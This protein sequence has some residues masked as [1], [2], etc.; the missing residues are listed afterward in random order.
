MASTKTVANAV[1]RAQN[2]LKGITLSDTDALDFANEI[3]QIVGTATFFDWRQATGTTFGTT[4]DTQDY[5]NVPSDFAA[6]KPDRVYIQDDAVST[7][8]LIPLTVFESLP[9][10]T[11][12]RSRPQWISVE[13]G[14]FRLLP[15]PNITRSVSGQWAVKFEYWKR[16]QRLTATTDTFEFD[17]VCF[18][19]FA[20]GMV[21]RAAKFL[22][23]ARAGTWGGRSP[24]TSQFQG[25]GMWGEFAAQLNN[26][27]AQESLASGVVIYAPTE[28]LL[29][30]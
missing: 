11:Q 19:T 23:D 12:P 26:M 18:E 22:D 27:V 4:A 10:A 8:P 28:G 13:N 6:L 1:T 14:S 24:I 25:T 17:D 21:A 20:S 7:N 16:P 9:K 30:G 5:A 15:V 3:Y 2:E 29:R